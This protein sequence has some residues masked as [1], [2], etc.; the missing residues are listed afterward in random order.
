MKNEEQTVFRFPFFM[1]IKTNESI[2][3]SKQ[4]PIKHENSGKQNLSMKL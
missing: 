2:E 3:N 1:K 4:K